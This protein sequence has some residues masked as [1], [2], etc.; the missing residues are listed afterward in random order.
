M[1]GIL[2]SWRSHS[3]SS[4]V[5]ACV[6]VGG[7]SK[8]TEETACSSSLKIDDRRPKDDPEVFFYSLSGHVLNKPGAK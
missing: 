3:K 6:S 4:K 8:L 2:A 1:V 7:N 5:E